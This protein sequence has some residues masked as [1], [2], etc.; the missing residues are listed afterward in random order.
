LTAAPLPSL[1]GLASL[2][3]GIW[4]GIGTAPT[5]SQCPKEPTAG[6]RPRVIPLA[7]GLLAAVLSLALACSGEG[8][9]S[10]PPPAETAPAGSSPAPAPTEPRTGTACRPA[11]PARGDVQ[12][13]EPFCIMWRDRFDNET[14]FR[15]HVRYRPSGEEF[16][17]RVGPNV[18]EVFLPEG[19]RPDA[20]PCP[21]D[22]NAPAAAGCAAGVRRKDWEVR[23]V[24]ETPS[25][26]VLVG[27]FVVTRL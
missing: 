11:P 3:G 6:L 20:I 25:G 7:A 10:A 27:S 14:G 23:V 8:G 4:R 21:E 22:L 24:A 17:Y 2:W 18:T 19:E 26:E 13:G 16:V 15:V 1:T 12:A 9:N 5:E